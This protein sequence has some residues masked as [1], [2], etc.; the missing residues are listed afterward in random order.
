MGHH[1][2]HQ[3]NETATKVAVVIAAVLVLGKAV[4]WGLTHS[5]SIQA[6]M[7]DSMLDIGAS[8]INFFAVKHAARPADEEHR[9]GH[10]KLEALAALLQSIFIALSAGWL[11]MEG[12]HRFYNPSPVHAH[13]FGT[14]VMISALLLTGGLVFFQRKVYKKTKSVAIKADSLHYQTDFLT[15]AGVLISLHLTVALNFPLIDSIIGAGI[16][17]YIGVTSWGIFKHAFDELMDRALSP[18]TVQDIERRVRAHPEVLDLHNLRT[19]SS[20]YVQFIQMDLDLDPKLSLMAAHR[21]AHEVMNHLKK[22]Y[23]HAEI[24]IHQDPFGFEE[25]ED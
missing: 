9:F 19:R 10:G 4:A 8:L 7:I 13:P 11:V 24:I 6:S 18:S 12:V 1:H 5:L 14:I 17:V 22:D 2:H 21:I 16:A 15:N 25:R 20:G 23:P 3:L